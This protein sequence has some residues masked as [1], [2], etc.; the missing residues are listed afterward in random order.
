M[1][2][3]TEKDLFNAYVNTTMDKEALK[4]DEKILAQQAKKIGIKGK[5]NTRIKKVAEAY[6]KAAFE[7]KAEEFEAFQAK[8]EELTK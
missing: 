3:N 1:S 2:I 4:E 5:E 6:V 7:E 8:Y